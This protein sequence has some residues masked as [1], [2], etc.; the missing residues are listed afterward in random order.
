[1]FFFSTTGIYDEF[2]Y[3]NLLTDHEQQHQIARL[4]Q[5]GAGDSLH[6]GYVYAL[7]FNLP[8]STLGNVEKKERTTIL[9]TK[10]ICKTNQILS[11]I[12]DKPMTSVAGL[13]NT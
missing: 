7:G 2:K 8:A 11:W 10:Q 9:S 1:M 3:D 4:R 6:R 5:E 12:K 13:G